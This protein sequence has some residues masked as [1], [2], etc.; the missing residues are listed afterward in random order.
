MKLCSMPAR[1]SSKLSG[2]PPAVVELTSVRFQVLKNVTGK[3]IFFCYSG[4]PTILTY[5][6]LLI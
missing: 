6:M 4:R 2:K 5:L 3:N 1:V